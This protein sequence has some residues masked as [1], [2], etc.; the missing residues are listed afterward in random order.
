MNMASRLI[1][2][3]RHGQ[4]QR[5]SP[6]DLDGN[7]RVEQA[8]RVDGGL[9][10]LGIEQ[11][12]LT[13]Q[14]LKAYPISAIYSSSLPRAIQT[15]EIIAQELPNIPLKS[16]RILW[17]CIPCIPPSLAKFF[18]EAPLEEVEQGRK[19]AEGAYS[20]Y[21]KQARGEDKHEV[22]VGHGN[23]IRYFVSRVLEAEPETWDKML[24]YNCGVSQV[25]ISHRWTGV[26]YHNHTGHLPEDMVTR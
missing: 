9:T 7:A 20:R 21:F 6:D 22:I 2:L 3:V 16:T 12:K 13:A 4:Y 14:R 24:I 10:P 1:Y 11:A 23:L 17:E 5:L 19:Q 18:L 25:E 8:I 15:A 26:V